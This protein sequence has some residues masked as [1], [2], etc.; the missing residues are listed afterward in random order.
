MNNTTEKP[1]WVI[2]WDYVVEK[3]PIGHSFIY[4]GIAMFVTFSEKCLSRINIFWSVPDFT[5]WVPRPICCEYVNDLGEIKS[6][7]FTTSDIKTL[8]EI[9]NNEH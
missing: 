1:Q 9:A 2:E 7:V 6:K 5:Y 8:E 3:Y 4:L